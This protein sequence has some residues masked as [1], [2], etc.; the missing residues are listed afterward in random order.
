M[1][2]ADG[3]NSRQNRGLELAPQAVNQQGLITR[4]EPLAHEPPDVYLNSHVM[5]LKF[6]PAANMLALSQ[7]TGQLRVYAYNEEQMD[8]VITLSHHTESVRSLDF[9]PNGHIVYAASKDR[10]FSVVSGGLVQ[11]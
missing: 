8:E 6:S 10:S 9:S 3:G 11:G 4:T 7:V 5:D 2:E 1:V